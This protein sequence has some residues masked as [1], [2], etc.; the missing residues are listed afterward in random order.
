ICHD[1]TLDQSSILIVEDSRYFTALENIQEYHG[2]Y[3]V[4]HGLISPM[5]CIGPDDINLKTLLTRLM[6]NEVTEV[7]VATNAT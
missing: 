2:L 7:I 1:S 5:N 4:L 3:H 6:D